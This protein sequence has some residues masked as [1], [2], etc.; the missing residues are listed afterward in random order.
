MTST[1]VHNI[2]AAA[3]GADASKLGLLSSQTDPQQQLATQGISTPDSQ[4]GGTCAAVGGDTVYIYGEDGACLQGSVQ[5]NQSGVVDLREVAAVDG[6]NFKVDM[7]T[8]QDPEPY[9]SPKAAAAFVNGTAEY[10]RQYPGDEKRV[11]VGGGREDG[12]GHGGAHV[13]GNAIDSRYIDFQGR[14]IEKKGQRAYLFADPVRE[15]AFSRAMAQNG[16]NKSV[17][18]YGLKG[19]VPAALYRED[20]GNHAHYGLNW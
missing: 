14:S 4:N 1:I 9:A 15:A 17:V 3:T 7:S 16:L 8:S 6:V 19:L 12:S 13:G 2:F 20:H 18:A 5:A 11:V 10:G